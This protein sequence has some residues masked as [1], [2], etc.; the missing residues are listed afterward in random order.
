MQKKHGIISLALFLSLSTLASAAS[1]SPTATPTPSTAPSSINQ[2][3]ENIKKYLQNAQGST[4]EVSQTS[5]SLRAYVGTVR[6]VIKETIVVEDKDGKKNVVVDADSTILR[7]PGNAT[8]KIDDVRIDDN[9]I[10]IGY[11]KDTDE[12]TGRRLIVSATPLATTTKITGIGTM[13]KISGSTITVAT[14]SESLVLTATTKTI[15]KSTAS[16][17]LDLTELELGDTIIFTATSDEKTKTVT[18]IMRIKTTSAS[19]TP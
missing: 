3:T 10:A 13:S 19:P 2:A 17:T 9:I 8:I 4:E 6:D 15:I 5:S 16:T 11:I 14:S 1:P 7:S 18:N 12:L